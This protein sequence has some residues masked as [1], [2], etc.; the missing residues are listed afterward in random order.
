M[1]NFFRLCV[2]LTLSSCA[3]VNNSNS[4]QEA[5]IPKPAPPI[6]QNLSNEYNSSENSTESAEISSL[7]EDESEVILINKNTQQ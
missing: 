1:K 2:C 5:P 3:W 7:S 4:M 6:I